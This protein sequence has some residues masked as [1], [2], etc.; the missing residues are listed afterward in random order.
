MYIENQFS[1][2]HEKQARVHVLNFETKIGDIS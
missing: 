2:K 1:Q